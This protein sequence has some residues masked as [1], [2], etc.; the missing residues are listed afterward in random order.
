MFETFVITICTLIVAL[1]I[2]ARAASREIRCNRTRSEVEPARD[3]L[4]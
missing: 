1:Y 2:Q 4:L 3:M